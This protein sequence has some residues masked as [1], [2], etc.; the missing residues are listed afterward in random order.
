M[1]LISELQGEVSQA[2]EKSIEAVRRDFSS[3]RTGRASKS[4]L[5]SVKV[6]YYGAQMAINQVANIAVPEARLIEIRPFDKSV[7]PELEKAILQA[8]LGLNPQGDGKVVRIQF[9]PLTEER[10]KELAKVVRKMAEEGRVA[11]RSQRRDANESIK[12]Y[13]KEKMVSEDEAA[14]AETAVQKLTDACIGKIDEL[15]A[16]KEK[17][18][19]EI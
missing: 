19:L 8:N 11:V 1:S 6:E 13:Q 2:M 16:G 7:I 12:E 4:I 10:R 17:E 5:D 15:L 3:V 14:S 18:I 9:P